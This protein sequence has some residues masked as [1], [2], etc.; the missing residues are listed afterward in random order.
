MILGNFLMMLVAALAVVPGCSFAPRQLRP[1]LIRQHLTEGNEYHTTKTLNNEISENIQLSIP[2]MAMATALTLSL[3]MQALAVAADE[4]DY[5][6]AELPPPYIPVIFT[7]ALLGGVGWLTS[8]LGNVMD[9]EAS[10]GLQ[11]GA[12][13]KKERERSSS[14]YF[15]KR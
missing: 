4:E 1:L 12:R 10:L 15:K 9:E 6:V 5:A 3:P 14:S 8:S 11:S 13:A 7:L 2:W